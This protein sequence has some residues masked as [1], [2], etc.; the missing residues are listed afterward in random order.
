MP[1]FFS[2]CSNRRGA[3]N[4]RGLHIVGIKALVGSLSRVAS[5][6]SIEY[7]P[8]IWHNGSFEHGVCARRLFN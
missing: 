7:V 4:I 5:K 2:L 1:Y 3:S 6:N 8:I